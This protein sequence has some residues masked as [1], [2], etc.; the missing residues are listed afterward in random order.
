MRTDV[1]EKLVERYKSKPK[2]QWDEAQIRNSLLNPFWKELGWD[3]NDPAQ[4]EVERRVNIRE[5]IKFADYAF[6]DDGRTKF[7][8][9]AKSPAHNLIKDRDAIFQLKRYIWNTP[10]VYLGILQ[11]FEEFLPII[12][13]KEPNINF[14]N[15]GLLK[16]R[17]MKYT[18]YIDRWDELM[19]LYSRDSVLGGSLE[20]FLPEKTKLEK[21][22]EPVDRKF[23]DRLTQWRREI[24][25]S[26]AKN[27]PQIT[28]D[29]LNEVV[30]D[31]LNRL[32]FIRVIED[33][34]IEPAEILYP[35]WKKWQRE[36]RG[37]LWA[38]IL[39]IFARLNPKY[40]GTM[41]LKHSED[42]LQK[43]IIDD[44]PLN[45]LIKNLYYPSP[46]QFSILP[47]EIIGNAYEKYLGYVL[48]TTPKRLVK[49]E[50]KPEVRKAGGVY[51]TPKYI[52]D[53]IV[54]QTVG[55]LLE[56]KKPRDVRKIKILDPA[57]GSGSFLIGAYERI[58]KY[59]IDYYTRHPKEN[60]GYLIKTK[61]GEKKLS[62]RLKK[63]IL[64]DN[65]YGVD[66]DQRAVEITQFSL[67]VKMMEGEQFRSLFGEA[68]LPDLRNNIKCGN[69]LIGWDILDMGILPDDIDE[70]NEILAKINPMN[71]EDAFP[72]V[73]NKR[74]SKFH[75]ITFEVKYSRRSKD[76]NYRE[77]AELLDEKQRML[78]ARAI[79]EKVRDKNYK[80]LAC[81]ILPDHIHIVIADMGEEIS[82]IVNEIKGYSAYVVNRTL[83]GAV[84]GG[85]RQMHLWAKK[86]ND[87]IL[88][89]EE[90]LFN[91]IEYV[92][93]NYAKHSEWGEPPNGL[94]KEI[95]K[96]VEE[97]KGWKHYEYL[98]S[99]FDVVIG[100][101]PYIR[102]E[103]IKNIK[104]IFELSFKNVYM[105]TADLYVYFFEK[106]MQILKNSGFFGFIVSNKFIRAGYGKKLRNFLFQ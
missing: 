44:K 98:A 11:D 46:Y 85:G 80:V 61:D 48:R 21:V 12:V 30:N 103:S 64:S 95:S 72:A 47:V 1:I 78:V 25:A 51:Y 50:E 15:E 76:K 26:I 100:N 54:E 31:I 41:F 87:S 102:Q 62:L 9:E 88:D 32:L 33:R 6:I 73:F 89:T 24:A 67:Y 75:L 19:E 4:V 93:N 29:R 16:S 28:D 34:E 10:Q 90:H 77:F 94:V 66:I 20:K 106:S 7:L 18:E 42:P 53:Y 39:D 70:R 99:G 65:I 43:I 86:Y 56:D 37:S 45:N 27:N 79:G 13:L 40:N 2:S 104:P 84:Q 57:C 17:Y 52:V 49:L 83:K 63:Q 92:N 105:G 69:S 101:P 68:I 23:F 71:W 60:K 55:R 58:M 38:Y 35:E 5:H 82:K 36:Q 74:M 8:V 22:T 59:Y 96:F 3:I 97:F 81:S 14:P 91:A